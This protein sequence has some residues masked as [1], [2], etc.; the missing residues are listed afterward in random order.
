MARIS[1]Y[2]RSFIKS[3]YPWAIVAGLLLALSFP[4]ISIAGLAWI[5]PG[6]ILLT[7]IG[8]PA[9]TVF[10]I[11]YVAG[12]AHYLASLYW[13]LL[14]PVAWFPILGWL[15][16]SGFLALFT[17]TWTWACWKCFPVK[18]ASAMD[19]KSIVNLAEQ[20]LSVPW[21]SRVAWTITGGTTWVALEM[22][23]SRIFGG[24]PWNLL[25]SSQYKLVPLIQV[26]SFTGI[27]GVS[28]LL[29]WTSLSFVAAGMVIVRRPARR[30][31][32]VGEIIL[33]GFTVLILFAT[34]YHQTLKP[35]KAPEI[36][37]ASIQPSIPQTMIWNP[38]DDTNRFHEL[39]RLTEQALK[40]KSDIVLW[41][42][43][44]LPRMIRY[45]DDLHDAVA[46]LAKS[47][48]VWMIIGSDDMEPRP[49]ATSRE[50]RD[51]FNSSFLM[52]PDG[53]LIERYKKRNLVI[54]GEYIPLLRWLPFIKYFTPIEGSFTPGDS[55]V[56]F[57]LKDLNI[58]V[59]V[60]ICFEDTFPHL[61]REYVSGDTDFLV[62][63]TNDGWFGEGAAQWQHAAA[64]IFRTVENGVP[65]VRCSNTGLTCWID[66]HGRVQEFFHTPEHGIY[67]PG[68]LT[69]RIPVLLPG[70]TR[71]ATF[72][73][74]HGDVFGWGCVL[75]AILQLARNWR[76]KPDNNAA[77]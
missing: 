62:N 34:G 72:Y 4:N 61:V 48:K 63:L 16:L 54:F 67:G 58:N 11:G 55:V 21:A 44:A 73:R 68:Y 22:L 17:A 1:N 26:A 7:A 74:L 27:Y 38:A 66:S 76:V 49:H 60:L 41:P 50:E 10:R 57:K 42:E 28:F 53:K 23:V 35:D 52:T 36:T 13:L 3:R 12:L 14:I 65:L 8:K 25:A 47:H 33:P 69:A 31:A 70:E 51:Y 5:A 56:P 15:A 2:L 30:S 46:N 75:F 6:L 18:L 40:T 19:G 39:L 43:A 37:V 24:F 32:W 59:S 64:A 71:A 9:R 77:Q 45:D 20:F 29:V